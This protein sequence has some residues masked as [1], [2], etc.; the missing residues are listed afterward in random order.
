VR[1]VV[2]WPAFVGMT[3][4]LALAACTRLGVPP[5]GAVGRSGAAT[6]TSGAPGTTVV[7]ATSTEPQD[8]QILSAWSAAERAFDTA[9]L[10]A[11]AA[12]P[13]LAATMVEPQLDVERSWLA[14]LRAQGQIATGQIT[15]GPALVRHGPSGAVQVQSCAH[16]AEIVVSASTGQPVAGI[17]GEVADELVTATMVS[18]GG[19][20]KLEAQ[21]VGVGQCAAS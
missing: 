13:A 17:A 3:A 12:E 18:S 11:D 5:S 15:F 8:Q 2:A 1:P 21:T 9:A 6:A 19:E 14:S 20:W 7:P 10:T 16:D 4:C